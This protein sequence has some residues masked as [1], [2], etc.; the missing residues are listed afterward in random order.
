MSRGI[1]GGEWAAI[2]NGGDPV[3][4]ETRKIYFSESELIDAIEG[5]AKHTKRGMPP[6][7]TVACGINGAGNLSVSLTVQNLADGVSATA[8]FDH[9]AVAAALIRYCIGKKI[10]LAKA[11]EKSVQADGAGVALNLRIPEN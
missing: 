10:P 5:F 7:K 9:A 6:G 3:P 1:P 11:A 2:T 8:R 4:I